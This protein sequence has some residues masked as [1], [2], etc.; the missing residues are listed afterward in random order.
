MKKILLIL[1]VG[2][3]VVTGVS[4]FAMQWKV[5]QSIDQLFSSLF[6]VDASY[7]S[8]TM[9]INGQIIV[10]GIELFIPSN[11]I[12]VEMASVSVSPG[13]FWAALALQK[14]FENG[15]LPA[16]LAL[17]ISS[18]SMNIDSLVIDAL[19]SAYVP[20]MSEQVLALGC[21]EY[22]SLG[23]KQLFDLGIRTISFD[24]S[25]GY[26]FNLPSDQ[27]V[28]SFELYLDGIG[29]LVVDQTYIGFADLMQNYKSA[30]TSFD[31]TKIIPIDLDIQYVDLGYNGK[32]HEFCA[33]ASE[34][35]KAEWLQLNRSMFA[36]V[37]D[38]IEFESDL[39]A[40]KLYSDV[41]DERARINLN[42]RPLPSF[43]M[44]DMA[45]YDMSQLIELLELTL[46][47]N[48]ESVDIGNVT[49]NQ[50][51]LNNLDLVKIRKDFR[52]GP[53]TE[54]EETAEEVGN[55]QERILKEVPTSTLE[56][57]LHRTVLLERKDGKTFTGE[58]WSVTRD[59]I[60]IR[61][62]F[63]SGYTDLPLI[64][65]EVAVAKLYPEE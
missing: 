6:F 50:S 7:E 63:R 10:S 36:A 39:D 40:I 56:Q 9:D 16:S 32:V 49:W 26:D 45:F 13:S 65:N 19:E 58:L 27:L 12:T 24:M 59:R 48:N 15:K 43:N 4:Y 17:N 38:Q 2:F 57:Y 3:V 25:L 11:Q 51:K 64:R 41:L 23:P 61:T 46:V 33:K 1:V 31:P 18:F 20:G 35:S 55:S 34:I 37:L 28:S 8:A 29:H 60:V 54:I 53:K 47:V 30:L 5:K 21:G 14:D 42:M 62:R 52:V 44:D 22:L